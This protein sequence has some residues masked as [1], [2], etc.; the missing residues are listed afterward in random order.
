M[1]TKQWLSRGRGINR[2]IDALLETK[3]QMYE[4]LISITSAPTGDVVSGTKD[5]HK[6]DK[7]VELGDRIDRRI[8]EL[9]GIKTE[10]LDAINKLDDWRYREVLRSRYIDMKQFEQIAVDM[11]YSWRQIMRV[12]G[13]ALQAMERVIEC[14]IRPVV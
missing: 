11:H 7:L 6:F 13:S 12:H 8:D 10:I 9:A 14:H 1:N 2:E 5:P 4:Q 3:R